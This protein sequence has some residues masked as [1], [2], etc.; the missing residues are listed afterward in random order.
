MPQTANRI[1]CSGPRAVFR[2][3]LADDRGA[4]TV[5]W[6]VLTATVVGIGIAVFTSVSAGLYTL[7]DDV[8][9]HIADVEVRELGT[10]N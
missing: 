10:V 8:G 3:F 7:G 9:E 1:F 6:V 4:I 5:D 2:Q